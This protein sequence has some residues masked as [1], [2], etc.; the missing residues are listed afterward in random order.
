M[1]CYSFRKYCTNHWGGKRSS[2]GQYLL[3]WLGLNDISQICFIV[4]RLYSPFCP[5]GALMDSVLWTLF[6]YMGVFAL[7]AQV[8]EL[9]FRKKGNGSLTGKMSSKKNACCSC[10]KAEMM[11][12][13]SLNIEESHSLVI[14]VFVYIGRNTRYDRQCLCVFLLMLHSWSNEL[15]CLCCSPCQCGCCWPSCDCVLHGMDLFCLY[16]F[17]DI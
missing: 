8:L 12:S 3:M 6:Q 9:L 2:H 7:C 16:Y 5:Q 13:C 17:G 10:G 1:L 15:H 11:Q 14:H 4:Q